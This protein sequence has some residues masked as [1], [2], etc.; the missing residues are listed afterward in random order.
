MRSLVA[1]KVIMGQRIPQ[2]IRLMESQ[3]QSLAS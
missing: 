3:P 1:G 2:S